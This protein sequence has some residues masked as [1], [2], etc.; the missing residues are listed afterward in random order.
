MV[1]TNLITLDSNP[2]DAPS[3]VKLIDEY[4]ADILIQTDWEY[5]GIANTFGWDIRSVQRDYSQLCNKGSVP[6]CDHRGTDGT[7]DCPDC[8]I[9]AFEFI[10]V[11]ANWLH[12]H[13]GA[14]LLFAGSSKR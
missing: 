13:D 5:P 2:S 10:T 8:G 12:K 3:C 14:R 1:E 4:G 7:V 11:A 9:T 6:I